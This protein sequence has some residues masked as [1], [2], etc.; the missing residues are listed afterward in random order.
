MA[1]KQHA[2]FYMSLAW[3]PATMGADRYSVLRK[4]DG[5]KTVRE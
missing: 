2:D 4:I 3:G 1:R 5:K